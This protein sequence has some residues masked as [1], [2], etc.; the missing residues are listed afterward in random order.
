MMTRM[1]TDP[2]QAAR[3]SFQEACARAQAATA[4]GRFDQAAGF[5]NLASLHHAELS[6]L[7]AAVESMVKGGAP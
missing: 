7:R 2:I 1:M 3:D 6:R 5:L 4:A